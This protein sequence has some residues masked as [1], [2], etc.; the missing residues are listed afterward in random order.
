MFSLFS[1]PYFSFIHS[2]PGS[3]EQG[4]LQR[5]TPIA[6]PAFRSQVKP[7]GTPVGSG[8][9]GTGGGDLIQLRRA[10]GDSG[11]PQTVFTP[12]SHQP[13]SPHTPMFAL[14]GPHTGVAGEQFSLTTTPKPAFPLNVQTTPTPSTELAPSANE[15]VPP[16]SA[17]LNQQE[18]QPVFQ[19]GG[20]AVHQAT[21]T[22]VMN[23]ID[24]SPLL[25]RHR[26][27][28]TFEEESETES[29]SET[30]SHR[31][32]SLSPRS[33]PAMPSSPAHTGSP[34]PRVRSRRLLTARSTPN[35]NRGTSKSDVSDE[36]DEEDDDIV[37]LMTTS[38]RF[39]GKNSSLPRLSPTSSPLLTSR[40]S[41]TLYLTGSS[42]DEVSSVFEP[43]RKIR[44][45]RL[46]FRKRISAGKLVRMESI[47]SDDGSCMSTKDV[48]RRPHAHKR[49]RLLRLRQYSSLP[50]TSE[51]L[52][53]DSLTELLDNI[54]RQRSGSCRTD[55]S[56]S[57]GGK[58][59]GGEKDM[60]ELANS[61]VSKFELSDEEAA[62]LEQ[63]M[64]TEAL[65]EPPLAQTP[66][67]QQTVRTS[68]S[69]RLRSV[70]CAIL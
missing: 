20:A 17:P 51:N 18:T 5:R 21:P 48:I 19:V 35:V 64:E 6:S 16:T 38:G 54:R 40:R 33:S 62:S 45:K 13:F 30:N 24:H 25:Y 29:I 2:S 53:S 22:V 52:N 28:S 10:S 50:A 34:V 9:G 57:D 65:N 15:E 41:P 39:P 4:V 3:A 7:Q 59:G 43:N 49:D 23:N 66:T 47:S 55:S 56:L 42:D 46:P 68:N 44:H 14:S 8:G 1:P 37:A 67:Q 12:T 70:F 31:Q 58:S 11:T 32:A 61:L 63:S 27:L 36:E 26:A 60:A 69:T